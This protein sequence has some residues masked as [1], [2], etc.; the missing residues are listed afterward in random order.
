MAQS[1]IKWDRKRDRRV[2]QREA[3]R[4]EIKRQLQ[5]LKPR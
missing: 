5:E 1:Y 2:K 3:S 4:K